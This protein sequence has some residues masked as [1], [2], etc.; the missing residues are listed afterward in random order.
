MKYIES[1]REGERISEIY[2]DTL[3]R[4]LNSLIEKKLVVKEGKGKAT[5]Y[6]KS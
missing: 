6:I 2:R 5:H 1:L 3:I 4:T